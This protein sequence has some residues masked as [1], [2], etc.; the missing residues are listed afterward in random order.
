MHGILNEAGRFRAIDDVIEDFG[1]HPGAI[2]I[3]DM[4][5]CCVRVGADISIVKR[6][7]REGQVGQSSIVVYR[8]RLRMI[9]WQGILQKQIAAQGQNLG[10]GTYAAEIIIGHEVAVI[11]IGASEPIVFQRGIAAADMKILSLG[12]VVKKT[13]THGE[14]AA[15]NVDIVRGG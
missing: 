13:I 14:I 6:P 7:D 10:K 8:D 11:V 4:Y 3:G 12:A 15:V 5:E 2:R 9:S 1:T